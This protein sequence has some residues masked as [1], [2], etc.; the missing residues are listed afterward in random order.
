PRSRSLSG[1]SQRSSLAAVVLA[2]GTARRLGGALKPALA[3]GGRP[4]LLRVLDAAALASP[5][6]VVGPPS[7]APLLPADVLLTCE[8][9]PGGGPVAALSAA[10]RLI[11]AEVANVAVLSADLPFLTSTV[12]SG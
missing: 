2:G 5:R 3:V 10:V 7:L 6:V 12:L 9:P 8:A 11:P 4:L 1:S